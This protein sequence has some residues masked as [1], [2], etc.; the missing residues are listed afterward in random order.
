[1]IISHFVYVV[2]DSY[3][4]PLSQAEDIA[5]YLLC[6]PFKLFLKQFIDKFL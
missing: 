4:T 6:Q 2:E 3:S 5:C 1:M